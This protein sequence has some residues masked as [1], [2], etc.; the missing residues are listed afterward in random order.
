M[1]V[2]RMTLGEASVSANTNVDVIVNPAATDLFKKWG[3]EM[4]KVD[5][6]GLV[7]DSTKQAGKIP[8]VSFIGMTMKCAASNWISSSVWCLQSS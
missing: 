1:N 7:H 5:K 8:S 3:V 2:P 4:P 6:K